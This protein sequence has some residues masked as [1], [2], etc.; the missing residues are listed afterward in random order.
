MPG[1]LKTAT[2]RAAVPGRAAPEGQ[3]G[4]G[5]PGDFGVRRPESLCDRL[6]TRTVLLAVRL[7]RSSSPCQGQADATIWHIAAE[8]LGEDPEAEPWN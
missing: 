6:V 2:L 5:A 4:R 1:V 8:I 7:S 3:P